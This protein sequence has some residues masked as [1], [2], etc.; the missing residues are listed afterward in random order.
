VGANAQNFDD[1]RDH[2]IIRWLCEGLRRTELVQQ[3]TADLPSDLIARPFSRV[4]PLKGAREFTDG[5]IVVASPSTA[6]AT[7][8][9]LRFRQSHRCAA[10]PALW[11][12][13]KGTFTDSG[14]VRMLDRRSEQTEWG[15]VYPHQFRHTLANDLLDAGTEEGDL[16]R[17]MGWTDRSMVDLYAED[18]QVQRAIKAKLRRGDIY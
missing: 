13:R 7:V 2:A 3:Q 10:L 16:M 4:I 17:I 15:H 6:R 8:A 5:R 12:G 1:A 14:L 18:L 11:L 9:Y